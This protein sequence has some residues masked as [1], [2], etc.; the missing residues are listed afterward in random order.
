MPV[1]LSS[2]CRFLPSLVQQCPGSMS[3]CASLL[4]WFD[5]PAGLLLT[6]CDA[7]QSQALDTPCSS[8]LLVTVSLC[9]WD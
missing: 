1:W 2:S 4:L 5:M 7:A 9:S 3:S 8:G 6:S